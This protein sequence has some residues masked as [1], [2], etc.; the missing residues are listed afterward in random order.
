MLVFFL[1][2]YSGV[3]HRKT[4]R[5]LLKS[6][7]PSPTLVC[8]VSSRYAG[9]I[10]FPK[11]IWSVHRTVTRRCRDQK[12]TRAH[13]KEGQQF[14]RWLH[15]PRVGPP[16]STCRR[17]V[18]HNRCGRLGRSESTL[19]WTVIFNLQS[20]TT[21]H[22]DSSLSWVNVLPTASWTSMRHCEGTI[23]V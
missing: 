4:P 11:R 2:C 17:R 6:S 13:I 21:C 5:L 15:S 10:L 18:G 1:C 7:K 16:K 23:Y 22:T 8:D 20:Q 19:Q 9:L 12:A 3:A 14:L